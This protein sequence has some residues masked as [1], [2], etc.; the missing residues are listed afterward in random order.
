MFVVLGLAALGVGLALTGSA[1]GVGSDALRGDGPAVS[2]DD[3]LTVTEGT[4]EVVVVEN[5]STIDSVA[6][7]AS[8]GGTIRFETERRRGLSADERAQAEAIARDNETVD[9][10]LAA[11][12][13]PRVA[14]EPI[15]ELE[16]D[17]SRTVDVTGRAN[18]TVTT[19]E[20]TSD[21]F[22]FTVNATTVREGD[23]T[24][25]V[26]RKPSHAPNRASVRIVDGPEGDVRYAATVDLQ[27]ETVT[28]VVDWDAIGDGSSG[29][30]SRLGQSR[31][32]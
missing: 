7:E 22:T 30:E 24:V 16:A 18:E 17:A 6:V 29:V 21:T 25:V 20:S 12:S 1:F 5:V 28:G 15:V 4:D 23:G 9:R 10:A 27:N 19:T 14:V 8:D 31:P 26:D 32:G 13:D 3:D 2:V 11:L